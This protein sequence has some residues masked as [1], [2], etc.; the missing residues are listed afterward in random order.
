MGF[1]SRKRFKIAPGVR[2]NMGKKSVGVSIGGKG[3]RYSIN[4]RTGA[5]VTA[6]IP[7]TGKSYSKSMNR[8]RANRNS[9]YQR[10]QELKRMEKEL[11]KLQELERAKLE[12]ELF[13]NKLEILRSIHKEIGEILDWASISR[14][15]PPFSPGQKGPREIAAEKALQSFKPNIFQKWFKQDLKIEKTLNEELLKAQKEDQEDYNEWED[16]IRLAAG[17]LDGNTDACLRVIEEM[18]PFDNIMDFASGFEVSMEDAQVVEVEFD[19]RPSVIPTEVKTLTQTG[20]LSTRAMS[21]TQYFE[22]FQDYVCSCTLRIAS[23]LF[24]LLPLETV[25]IHAYNE[26]LNTATGY[27]ER[28]VILSVRIDKPTLQQLN[29]DLI[30]CSD[31]MI[32]FDHRMSFLKTKGFKPVEKIG[33]RN[34]K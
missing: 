21:K 1:G 7:G 22:L 16:L 12:V 8:N 4:S 20:R 25:C 10:N 17:V 29:F 6:R 34:Q 11:A 32:N 3:L 27:Q 31:S 15:P 24:A 18:S 2:L 9:T 30:D 26:Q 33:I 19:V 13:E 23:D 5:R 28:V 14:T